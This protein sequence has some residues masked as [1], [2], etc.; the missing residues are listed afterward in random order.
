VNKLVQLTRSI[1]LACPL[2]RRNVTEEKDHIYLQESRAMKF[3]T[4][5]EV[6]DEGIRFAY[7]LTTDYVI[8]PIFVIRDGILYAAHT[9]DITI[10]IMQD[11]GLLDGCYGFDLMPHDDN[12]IIS[13]IP[14]YP[15]DLKTA[16]IDKAYNGELESTNVIELD[17]LSA[18]NAIATE[19]EIIKF[20]RSDTFIFAENLATRPWLVA[21]EVRL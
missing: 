15:L 13:A 8:E 20:V 12:V 16:D 7:K 5:T 11:S 14:S 9:N 10:G 17:I 18:V 4:T 6:K 19:Q 3:L 2:D 1:A 21:K